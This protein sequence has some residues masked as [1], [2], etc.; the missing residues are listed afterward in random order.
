MLGR[1]RAE[2]LQHYG[3]RLRHMLANGTGS[4]RHFGGQ[5][6][7]A[8]A[9]GKES[10][11]IARPLLKIL[12]PELE[13]QT[14]RTLQGA[15]SGYEFLRDKAAAVEAVGNQIQGFQ[16]KGMSPSQMMPY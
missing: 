10:Y 16:N 14:T 7:H 12:A 9:I 4:L 3:T 5:L 8:Y 13:Q 15:A 6:D 2:N 1:V 11:Q